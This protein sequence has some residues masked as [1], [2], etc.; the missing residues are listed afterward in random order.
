MMRCWPHLSTLF[1]VCLFA[2]NDSLFCLKA[3]LV[4]RI[5]LRNNS[6]R[7]VLRPW[8][9]GITVLK[10]AST[11]WPLRGNL[12]NLIHVSTYGVTMS[13]FIN[14]RNSM[15]TL[16]PW[17]NGIHIGTVVIPGCYCCTRG[18]CSRINPTVGS[19]RIKLEAVPIF[20]KT[21]QTNVSMEKPQLIV[22]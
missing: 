10:H 17:L 21:H 6:V 19:S 20:V 15:T 2:F 14:W 16:S 13:P 11:L 3:T 8:P 1:L 18:T 9:S 4:I 12:W 22:F 5:S 7:L